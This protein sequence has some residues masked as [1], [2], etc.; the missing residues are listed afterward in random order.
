M[1]ELKHNRKNF[2]ILPII[3]FAIGYTIIFLAI[4]PIMKPVM[5][6]LDMLFLDSSPNY[7][8]ES[9]FLGISSQNPVSPD[10]VFPVF[11]DKVGTIKIDNTDVNTDIYFG[12]SSKQLI[13]GVGIYNGSFVPGYGKT[14]LV[15]GHNHTFFHTLGNAKIGDKIYINTNYGNYVYQIT[16]TK[17]ANSTDKTT[18]DL[19][20]QE[21]NIILYTCYPFNKIGI[22]PQR[23]FVYGKYL[24]GQKIDLGFEVN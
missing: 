10:F 23:Y 12:D 3:F 7:K 24:S 2:V 20:K 11:G 19:S 6:V 1:K 18:Y 16:E 8:G 14:I 13:K 4:Y 22:T 9:K 15:A 17:I 21:E 5:P